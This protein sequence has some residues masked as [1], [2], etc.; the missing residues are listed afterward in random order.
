MR[1]PTSRFAPWTAAAVAALALG[2]TIAGPAAATSYQFT[3]IDAGQP[4]E[5][6]TVVTGL[7]DAGRIAGYYVTLGPGGPTYSGF[8]ANVDGSGFTTIDRPGYPQTGAAGINGS[9]AIVGVSV[10]PSFTAT[11]YVRDAGGGYTTIDPALGGLTS[12]YSEAVGINDAGDIVGFY[13]EVLPPGPGAVR[14]LSH[15]FLDKGGVY[16]Q[17]DVPA[18]WGFGTQAYGINDAGQ[19]TG[20]YLDFTGT[21]HGFLYTPGLGFSAPAV[22]GGVGSELGAINNNG[23]YVAAAL[24]FDPLSPLGYDA[25]GWLH[26]ASGFQPF[27]LPGALSTEPF[28]V[29]DKGQVAGLYV[30]AHGQI[31]GFTATPVPEPATWLTM[32]TG[33]GLIGLTLRR[34]RRAASGLVG[35]L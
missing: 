11:G 19:V 31:L 20:G 32:V 21:P 15:G 5:L 18:A 8:T 23:D 26:T 10:S 17:F 6:G 4:F 2:L 7:N 9:G 24:A 35:L 16:S 30:S 28:T 29:N 22:P 3:T 14:P 1:L 25:S 34:R 33:M 12:A 27:N 13:T